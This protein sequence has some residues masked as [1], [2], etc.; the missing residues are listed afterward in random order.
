MEETMKLMLLAAA[1][2]AVCFLV[3]GLMDMLR[4]NAADARVLQVGVWYGSSAPMAA[5]RSRRC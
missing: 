2:I 1:G 3:R 5:L 4:V